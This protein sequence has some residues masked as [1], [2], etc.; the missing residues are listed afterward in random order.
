MRR[1]V[2][3]GNWKLYKTV[4]EAVQFIEQFKPLVLDSNHCDI[5]IAPTFTCLSDAVR[6]AVGSNIHIAG[7]DDF[8]EKEGAFTGEA[9][10]ATL[11]D[12]GNGNSH[13][14]KLHACQVIETK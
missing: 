13:T 9:S 8:W 5:V 6:A 4:K 2:I 10:A 11:A 12:L 3:A 1:P 14:C 7:Q